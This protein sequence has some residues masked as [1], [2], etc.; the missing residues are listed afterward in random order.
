V[1]SHRQNNKLP[2]FGGMTV[3]GMK[4]A[5]LMG[6]V[7][8][9]GEAELLPRVI[10]FTPFSFLILRRIDVITFRLGRRKILTINQEM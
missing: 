4:M 5:E 6:F 8:F 2:A 9:E 1:L 3:A 7:I 10:R